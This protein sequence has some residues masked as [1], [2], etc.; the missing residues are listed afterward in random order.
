MQNE[1]WGSVEGI[2]DVGPIVVAH[3][4]N[5][6][7]TQMIEFLADVLCGSRRVILPVSCFLGAYHVMTRYLRITKQDAMTA[8]E[9]TLQLNSPAFYEEITRSSAIQAIKLAGVYNIQSWDGY[10]LNLAQSFGTRIIFT[11]DLSLGR[12]EGFSPVLPLS[13]KEIKKYHEWV[14][15]KRSK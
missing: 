1:S 13:K 2:V 5:P 7:K 10:L 8:L 12:A 6:C 11:L 3:C 9:K 15:L 14:R 4:E